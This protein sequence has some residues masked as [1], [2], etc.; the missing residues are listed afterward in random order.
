MHNKTYK[1]SQ[2]NLKYNMAKNFDQSTFG[3]P[4]IKRVGMRSDL[5]LYVLNLNPMVA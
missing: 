5:L 2:I 3:Q 1:K 4:Q